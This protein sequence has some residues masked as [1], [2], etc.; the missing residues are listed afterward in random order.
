[1]EHL[2]GYTNIGHALPSKNTS[3]LNKMRRNS[4][5]GRQHTET[6]LECDRNTECKDVERRTMGNRQV[7]IMKDKRV[8]HKRPSNTVPIQ[9]VQDS[10]LRVGALA[11]KR[12][13]NWQRT[14]WVEAR[15]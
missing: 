4:N 7:D 1:M 11:W 13:Q 6:Q 8:W 12:A 2:P 10:R 5:M 3:T 14:E 15:P 9:G